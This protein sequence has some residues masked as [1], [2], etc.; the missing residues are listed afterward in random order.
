M[1]NSFSAL[2]KE[3]TIP[4]LFSSPLFLKKISFLKKNLYLLLLDQ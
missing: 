3:K 1:K 4:L 2:I